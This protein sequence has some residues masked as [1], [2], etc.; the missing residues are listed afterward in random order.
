MSLREYLGGGD[1]LN[2]ETGVGWIIK[3]KDSASHENIIK[4]IA[5]F[6]P[7]DMELDKVIDPLLFED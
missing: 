5:K 3:I 1:M 2:F 6:K 4:Q 7:E